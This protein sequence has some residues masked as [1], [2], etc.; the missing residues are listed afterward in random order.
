MASKKYTLFLGL[1]TLI[2]SSSFAQIGSSYDVSDSS[3]VPSRRLPQHSEFLAGNYNFPAKPRNQWE[4]GIKGGVPTISGDVPAVIPT[5]GFGA[6][7]RKAFGYVFS[8]RLEYI[9]GT[10]KGQHWLVANNYMKNPAWNGSSN[11]GKA[12]KGAL[13]DYITGA[14]RPGPLDNVY[15]NYRTKLQDLSLEGIVTLNNLRFHKSRTGLNFYGIAGI[16]ATAFN[17]SVNAL[18]ANG[19]TY[20]SRWNAIPNDA[21]H[22][23][24]KQRKKDVKATLDNTYETPYSVDRFR[25][26]AFGDNTVMGTGTV[27]VGVAFKLSK[28]FN[29]ALENRH[30][31]IKTDQ[32]DAQQWQEH[33]YGDAV[34][35]R[36][37]DSY[38]FFSLGINY[39][40]GAKS[41]EPLWWMNPLDYAYS[42]IR[43]P[44]LMKIK[45]PPLPDGDGDGV[46]D[47]FDN[48]PN[49]PAGCPVDSHGVS[50]DTDGDGVPDCKDKELI[51]PTQCQPVDADG[52]G[53]CPEAPRPPCCDSIVNKTCNLSNLP[54]IEF[55]GNGVKLSDD[56][57]AQ[58][59][60]TAAQ[61]RSN[62]ECNVAVI[63]YCNS[64]KAEQQR[65]WDR[66][67]AVIN[68]LVEKE[69]ISASRLIFNY[70][71]TG[72]D[73]NTVDLR[74]GAGQQGGA[75]V[76]APHPNLRRN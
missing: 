57:K 67:N 64:S 66:V 25:R 51:T 20:A 22:K 68:Y 42:E 49:T 56:A 70:A 29:I 54:T 58:L 55:A 76:P 27:G 36:D 60:S 5:W 31:F 32:L 46:T 61:M 34:H 73:C 72:G 28:K 8:L 59:S 75:N 7:V 24:R 53:K 12:Y 16:G 38:N 65:S 30:T 18:D 71:Q 33:A 69:G 63:G 26:S 62:P 6:H 15:Y 45:L 48:E 74:D 43:N 23:N 14:G 4:I 37:F 10:A 40:I 35:T 47:Q 21:T 41:V 9:N 50:R 3:V 52:I 44:K 2:A 39:N 11:P 17:I 1:L 13:V 19:N